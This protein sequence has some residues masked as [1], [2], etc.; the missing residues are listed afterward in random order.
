MNTEQHHSWYHNWNC[1]Q[2]SESSERNLNGTGTGRSCSSLLSGILK[3]ALTPL[4]WI[5]HGEGDKTDAFVDLWWGVLFPGQIQA[6]CQYCRVLLWESHEGKNPITCASA[7]AAASGSKVHMLAHL[8]SSCIFQLAYVCHQLILLIYNAQSG[9]ILRLPSCY[10]HR[11]QVKPCSV[12]PA[13][14]Y[15]VTVSSLCYCCI[16]HAFPLE[17]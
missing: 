7:A 16:S 5:K 13:E 2:L 14:Q 3:S 9:L 17:A 4:V 12:V 15:T 1:F 11:L 6:S 10:L 8:N